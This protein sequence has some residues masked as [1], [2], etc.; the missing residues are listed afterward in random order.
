MNNDAAKTFLSIILIG[1]LFAGCRE[2]SFETPQPRGKKAL[3]SIPKEL[4]GRFLFA[5]EGDTLIIDASGYRYV[6]NNTGDESGGEHLGDSLIVKR[7]KKHYFFNHLASGDWEL[8]I[9]KPER[10]G[11]VVFM[12]FQSR[13]ERF[14]DYI[15]RLSTEIDID[16]VVVNEEMRYRIDPSPS[17]LM[18]LIR[19]GYTTEIRLVRIPD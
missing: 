17:E 4:H 14:N 3:S 6:P 9:L 5:E 7:Y 18:D 13:N 15:T 16:S 8:G 2:L 10:N 11:D 19:K 12:T 1:L